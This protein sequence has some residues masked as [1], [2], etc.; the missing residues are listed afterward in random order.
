MHTGHL[1]IKGLKM[2]KSLKNFITIK[3]LV[4]QFNQRV[5]RLLFMKQTYDATMDYN[6]DSI[7]EAQIKDKRYA[8]FFLTMNAILLQSEINVPQKWGPRE[9]ELRDLFAEKQDNIHKAFQRNF[10]VPDALKEIDE[11]IT[12]VNVYVKT[13]PYVHLFLRT[14]FNYIKHIFNCLG[15]VYEQQQSLQVKNDAFVQTV[16]LISNLRDKIRGANKDMDVINNAA[17]ESKAALGEINSKLDTNANE[18]L[19]SAV[20]IAT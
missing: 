15:L 19:L 12:A 1:H 14:I 10:N 7:K 4:T 20:Q 5:L 13:K 8:E 3:H 2:S 9:F 18:T 17:L 16:S 11:I 6:D